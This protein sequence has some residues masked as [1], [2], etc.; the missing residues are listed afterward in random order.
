MLA[1]ARGFEDSISR[2]RAVANPMMTEFMDLRDK[3]LELGATTRYT[4]GE[5]AR[6]MEELAR[7]GLTAKQTLDSIMPT[8]QLAQAN[9]VS[10]ADAAQ[11]SSSTMRAFGMQ[12]EDLI[13]INDVLSSTCAHSA[14]TLGL[15]S[16][17][18]KTAGPVAKTANVSLSETAALIGSLANVGMT[19]SDA[20]TGIKQIILALSSAATTK[21]GAKVLEHYN[22]Q[23]DEARIKAED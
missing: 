23:L 9:M 15:M 12:T 16:E 14:S 5:V 17:A 1:V 19:G 8:L 18:M 21:K 11:I 4:A 3:A 2:V 7:K 10:V 6:G 20:G 13:H 22:I